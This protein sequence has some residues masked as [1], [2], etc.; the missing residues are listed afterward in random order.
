MHTTGLGGDSEVSQDPGATALL[1][2]LGPRRAV[3]VSLLASRFPHDVHAALDRQAAMPFLPEHAGR[4]AVA[5]GRAGA[6]RPSEAVEAELL[7]AIAEKPAPLDALLTSRRHH[8]A[9]R[10]LVGRGAALISA[11]TPSD[12]AH[13]LGL[14]Q[15][16]NR[17]A[18]VKAAALFAQKR[19]RLGERLA[20]DPESMSRAVIEA[21]LTASAEFILDASFTEDGYRE[22]NLS[23]HPLVQ[24]GLGRKPALVRL[25]VGLSAPLIA[26]GAAAPAYYGSV[27]GRLNTEAVIPDHADVANAIGAAVGHVRINSVVTISRPADD[28]FRVHLE[29]GPKNFVELADAIACATDWLRQEIP[30]RAKAN[31]APRVEITIR[32]DRQTVTVGNAEMFLGMTVSATGIGRPSF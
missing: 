18:A 10:R 31:G 19:T 27:A 7:T 20:A 23:A 16:W 4:F 6:G 5:S 28:L 14:H 13:V 24:A 29:E 8:A 12:A 2:R 26:L 32:E 30:R 25:E 21:V 3:P 1:L 17:E 15:A 22:P 9:M 11:Y